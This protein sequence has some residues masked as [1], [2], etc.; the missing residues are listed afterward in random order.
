MNT[1]QIEDQKYE[2]I[3]VPYFEGYKCVGYKHPKE[4]EYYFCPFYPLKQAYYDF[5]DTP[6]L[7][8]EKIPPKRYIFEETGEYRKVK[9][10]DLYLRKEGTISRWNSERPSLFEYKILRKVDEGQN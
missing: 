6:F 5:H 1:E 8:Y 4:G 2:R 9:T 7:V 10:G 3:S